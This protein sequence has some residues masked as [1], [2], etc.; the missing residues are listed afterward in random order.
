MLTVN[1]QDIVQ[2]EVVPWEMG[3]F[4]VSYVTRDGTQGTD[5][6]GSKA[7]AE[8]IVQRVAM[9]FNTSADEFGL[10]PRDVAAS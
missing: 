6:I 5:Q 7:E 8:A 9:R 3:E 10:L 4:G 1:E 2:A